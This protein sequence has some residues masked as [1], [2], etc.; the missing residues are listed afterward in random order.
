MEA[1]PLPCIMAPC[2]KHHSFTSRVHDVKL[3]LRLMT[4]V[5]I[6]VFLSRKMALMLGIDRNRVHS[7]IDYPCHS[8]TKCLAGILRHDGT[9]AD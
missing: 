8:L 2:L 4:M 6:M 9:L 3:V 5:Y 7:C 1:Q